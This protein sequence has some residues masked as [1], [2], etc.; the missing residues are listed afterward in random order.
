MINR[1][2]L[3]KHGC[4]VLFSVVVEVRECSCDC[5]RKKQDIRILCS[6]YNMTSIQKQI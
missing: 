2:Y 1:Y 5:S 3:I 4:L 6:S